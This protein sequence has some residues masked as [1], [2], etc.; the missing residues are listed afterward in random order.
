[1]VRARR[2]RARAAAA[3]SSEGVRETTA[4][5]A[6][7]RAKASQSARPMPPAPPVTRTTRPDKSTVMPAMSDPSVTVAVGGEGPAALL[8][9]SELRLARRVQL[10]GA[11]LEVCQEARQRL[12]GERLLDEPGHQ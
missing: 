2:P 9:E 7:A 3:T 12:L 11:R 6:P 5:S 1:M 4:R 8:R 10:L